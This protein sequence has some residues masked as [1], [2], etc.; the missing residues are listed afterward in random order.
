MPALQPT[1][2]RE[3]L[4]TQSSA[5]ASMPTHPNSDDQ[6]CPVIYADRVYLGLG[7]MH[8]LRVVCFETE[9]SIEAV[10]AN[11]SETFV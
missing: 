1:R 7:G 8:R 5:G 6:D 2:R 4:K 11:R 10:R 9:D 3:H